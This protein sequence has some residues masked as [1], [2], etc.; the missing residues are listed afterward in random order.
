[1]AGEVLGGAMTWRE[2]VAAARERGRFTFKDRQDARDWCTCAVGEQWHQVPSVIVYIDD[3]TPRDRALIDAGAQF[4]AAVNFNDFADAEALLG[5]IED[6]TLELK[7]EAQ[8]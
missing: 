1:R 8:P 2:R 5:A 4:C 6:R 7:R 3:Q